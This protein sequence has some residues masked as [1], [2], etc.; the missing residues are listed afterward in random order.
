[1]Q[2]VVLKV[3]SHGQ[4]HYKRD[5]ISSIHAEVAALNNLRYSHYLKYIDLVVI[6][7]NKSGNLC[8]SKPCS[9][10]VKFMN[11]ILIK[12]RYKISNIYYSDENSN[13]IKTTLQ[14]LI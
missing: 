3:F 8:N 1:V 11:T 7:I 10:C 9:N 12:R 6:R 4:N 2:N 5:N 13:I 14:K